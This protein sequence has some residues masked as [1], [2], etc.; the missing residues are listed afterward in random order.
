MVINVVP[1]Q[2]STATLYAI[3]CLE[4]EFVVTKSAFTAKL[5]RSL[6][7]CQWKNCNDIVFRKYSIFYLSYE[8]NS[9]VECLN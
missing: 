2:D 5:I 3:I 8:D 6:R 7:K 9:Y 4:T 1:N